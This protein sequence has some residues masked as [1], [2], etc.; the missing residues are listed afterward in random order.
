[1]LSGLGAGGKHAERDP[2]D[3]EILTEIVKK[4]KTLDAK[5]KELDE[6]AAAALAAKKS[7]LRKENPPTASESEI[8]MNIF[9]AKRDNLLEEI[10]AASAPQGKDFALAVSSEV[11]QRQT[12]YAKRPP[13]GGGG[14]PSGV[15]WSPEFENVQGGSWDT[16]NPTCD[17]LPQAPHWRLNQGSRM[18]NHENSQEFFSLSLPPAE[19]LFQ[20]RQNQFELLD[21][22][23]HAGVN[24]FATSQEIVREWKLMGEETLEFEN[25]KKLFAE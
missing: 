6:Q 1:M 17:D 7:K 10:Y 9:S 20:K 11:T 18:N 12:I 3:D 14:A 8:D 19:R 15:F 4:R 23:V 21:D 22:H 25:E 2:E 24:F 13:G 5:K 16:H